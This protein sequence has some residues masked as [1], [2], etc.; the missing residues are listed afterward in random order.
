MSP[1]QQM[2]LGSGGVKD[3]VYVDDVFSTYLYKAGGGTTETVTNNIDL[4]SD[5]GGLVW[6]KKRNATRNHALFDTVRGAGERIIANSTAAES[7]HTDELKS[8]TSTGFTY[9]TGGNTGTSGHTYAA[10]TF[11]KQESFL[12]IVQYTG[13]QSTQVINHG[14]KCMPGFIMLRDLTDGNHW[15]CVHRNNYT[16]H[17]HLDLENSA[18]TGSDYVSGVTSTNF[19]LTNDTI[20]NKSGN[21]YIAY[22]FAGGASQATRAKSIYFNHS[23]TWLSC[24]HGSAGSSDFSFGTGDFTVE[25][26]VRLYNPDIYHGIFQVADGT[27]TS[28]NIGNTIAVVWRGNNQHWQVYGGASTDETASSRILR[29]GQWAHVA[30][31][32]H[33]STLTLYVDGE[34]H[35]SRSDTNNYQHTGITIGKAYSDNIELQGYISNFRV[36][37]GTAVYTSSFRPP[38]EPLADI[39]GAVLNC[40]NG[41][42]ATSSTV[43]PSGSSITSNGSP[44]G[45]TK[46]PFDDPKN[47]IFGESGDKNLIVCQSYWGNG[48]GTNSSSSPGPTVEL[49]WQPQWVM[50]KNTDTSGT[51]WYMFDDMRG[52]SIDRYVVLQANKE[53]EEYNNT[54]AFIRLTPTGFQV[55][56]TSNDVNQDNKEM[57][58]VAIRRVDGVVGKPYAKTEGASIFAMDMA[59]SNTPKYTSNFPVDM[60]FK[61]RPAVTENWQIGTRPTGRLRGYLDNTTTWGVNDSYLWD[62]S[63]YFKGGGGDDANAYQ[64]WMFKRHKG[65]DIIQ[66]L[67]TADN[68]GPMYPHHLG[69]VPQLKLIK[70]MDSTAGWVIGGNVF[71]QAMGS[72]DSGDYVMELSD[73]GFSMTSN[74]WATSDTDTHF[75]VRHGNGAA[76]GSAN[77]YVC[78]LLSDSDVS[79]CG[80]YTGNGTSSSSTQTITTGFQPRFVFFKMV[81]SGSSPSRQWHVLDTERGWGSGNDSNLKLNSN[82]AATQHDFG[83]PT[84]TGFTLQGNGTGYNDNGEK[85][86]YYAIA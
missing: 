51:S 44:T 4:S 2:L 80:Y 55:I 14:L 50:I 58:F 40:C 21:S 52:I 66:F 56:N 73:E 33:N 83:A 57:M 76:G 53:D 72:G 62:S 81:Y 31:V 78:I 60:L 9:G 63:K 13:N 5:G 23:G 30:L 28:S 67:G 7:T 1:I 25:C 19:T 47:F 34:K 29:E 77:E 38:T 59:A 37:K 75:S 22:V 69:Q 32:R 48:G 61:R 35:L 68:P 43:I 18:G 86:I 45:E 70:R 17:L 6:F 20:T 16:H 15:V 8:F 12:D 39:S 64:A 41:T 27:A 82:A 36:V 79:K 54:S 49:G 3:K 85:Y 42:G 26:Y 74:Y 46:T 65:L 24:T 71:A 11:K 84:S 10:W